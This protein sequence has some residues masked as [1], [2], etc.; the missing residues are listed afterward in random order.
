LINNLTTGDDPDRAADSH[1][2]QVNGLP[3]GVTVAHTQL[4][5][6]GSCGP[7]HYPDKV[8]VG[9]ACAGGD[10][11]QYPDLYDIT[12]I[13]AP[14]IENMGWNDEF[15]G[16]DVS[17]LGFSTLCGEVFQVY[18]NGGLVSCGQIENLT[19]ESFTATGT[20]FSEPGRFELVLVDPS[21]PS[22]PDKHRQGPAYDVG[23]PP[24]KEVSIDR[25]IPASNFIGDLVTVRGDHFIPYPDSI[26]ITFFLDQDRNITKTIHP[27]AVNYDWLPGGWDSLTFKVPEE[28]RRYAGQTIPFEV[29]IETD[30]SSGQTHASSAFTPRQ[31]ESAAWGDQDL[32]SFGESGGYVRSAAVGDIDGDGINDLVV[33]VP[34]ERSGF[35]AVNGAVYI[36]FGPVEGASLPTGQQYIDLAE[37]SIA[38][39]HWDVVIYGDD[40]DCYLD[41]QFCRRIGGALALGDVNGDGVNDILIGTTD[42][43]DAGL[44]DL[45]TEVFQGNKGHLPGKAFVFFGRSRGQWNRWYEIARDEYDVLIHG[46]LQRE[47][48]KQVAIGN[49]NG[50]AYADLIVSAPSQ[51]YNASRPD[52]DWS[53]RVYVIF[54]QETLPREI[55][56]DNDLRAAVAGVI[57][58][59]ESEPQ[60]QT[61]Y[62]GDLLGEGL[63]VGDMDGD[64]RDD[65]A[66]GAPGFFNSAFDVH[67]RK[68]AVF[69]F[70]GAG[71]F[72][73]PG[74]LVASRSADLGDQDLLIAGPTSPQSPHPLHRG[75]EIGRS[76][77][78]GDLDGDGKG[79][80]VLAAP[81]E[82]LDYQAIIGMPS[83]HE[84]H[85]GRI[86]LIEG[87]A[88][89]GSGG[90][91]VVDLARA[92]IHG[93]T[94]ISRLGGAMAVGDVNL[95]GFL[96]LVA[97]AP[98]KQGSE[99]PG[100]VWGFHGSPQLPS[101]EIHLT[102]RSGVPED[103]IIRG[104]QAHPE[105]AG[106]FGSFVTVGDLAPFAGDDVI[107]VDPLA[108]A[109]EPS[110]PAHQTW[111]E[112]AGMLYAF[113]EGAQLFLPR[114]SV[115]PAS[116]DFG[117]ISG[118]FDR[119][120]TIDVV[121]IG[122]GRLFIA[123][124]GTTTFSPWFS[125]TNDCSGRYLLPH[126][127]CAISVSLATRVPGT[128]SGILQI[129]SNDPDQGVID[130]PVQVD[131]LS[132]PDIQVAPRDIE[133]TG[134]PLGTTAS[135]EVTVTNEGNAALR[136]ASFDLSASVHYSFSE[137]CPEVLEPQAS[138][139]VTVTY[140]PGNQ[141]NV[142]HWATLAVLSDDPD[143]PRVEVNLSGHGV[144]PFISV[145]PTIVS[146]GSDL[147]E[148]QITLNNTSDSAALQWNLT[149]DL[150]A[151]LSVSEYGGVL[152]PQ[153]SK[154]LLL[155]VDRS[156]LAA[157]SYAH[158]LTIV[159]NGG[160]QSVSLSMEAPTFLSASPASIEF[161]QARQW[162]VLPIRNTS[163]SDTVLEWQI[164][165]ALPP[166][167]SAS[168][169][170]G[171]VPV[172]STQSVLLSVDR[173]GLAVGEYQH[174]LSLI[175]NGGNQQIGIALTVA[176]PL[177]SFAH[178]FGGEG[179][180]YAAAVRVT[181]DGGFILI[182]LT[183]SF[184]GGN[185]DVWLLKLDGNGH[186]QWEKTIGAINAERGYD[187][188]ETADHGY[189][190][191]AG[192]LD[193][194]GDY[195]L[196]V[197]KLTSQGEIEWQRS[198]GGSPDDNWGAWGINF[199]IRQTGEGGY[200]VA[201][202]TQGFGA[203]RD[204]V[205]ILKL[206]ARGE[207]EWQKRYGGSGDDY[208][209]WIEQT[210]D[211]G[212]IVAGVTESFGAGGPDIWVLKLDASGEVEWQKTYGGS[213]WD[214]GYTIRPTT[215][216]G[217][218]LL[219]TT[220][221]FGG[222]WVLK[223]DAS[224]DVT[225]QKAY[226]G[227]DGRGTDI[228]QTQEGGYILSGSLYTPG[229]GTDAWL[230]KL[231]AAGEIEWQ[232]TYG[233]DRV[234]EFLTVEQTP[235]GGFVAGG[236]SWSFRSD[237]YGADVELWVVRTDRWGSLGN[238][239]NN[240]KVP[241]VSAVATDVIP[242]QSSVDPIETTAEPVELGFASMDSASDVQA[243]CLLT[244]SEWQ[245]MEDLDINDIPANLDFSAVPVEP[246]VRVSQ[247]IVVQNLGRAERLTLD[248]SLL[249]DP[250]FTLFSSCPDQLLPAQSCNVDVSFSPQ[251]E[252]ERSARLIVQSN[253]P[254][255][256]TFQV[257]ITGTGQECIKCEGGSI[258]PVP[259][260]G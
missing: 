167:L 149:E 112:K 14:I 129:I 221:T 121:N 181:S 4:D 55:Q 158:T 233:G 139:K 172:G 53:G 45:N 234:D 250:D 79:E 66:V 34:E 50:D 184:G 48:G 128:Y 60:G 88:L 189:V 198:Y 150:P 223:L 214:L 258:I 33:G 43:N 7:Y 131:I 61:V 156:G 177:V 243:V 10:V 69:L 97:G 100:S 242:Q 105:S 18:W 249:G 47:L 104:D 35:G 17:G 122:S 144:P 201:G 252:G 154:T 205:W 175:S 3:S 232:R 110:D 229:G 174:T 247:S 196:L 244:E 171:Q 124:V 25:V 31:T 193:D 141:V 54:G 182:G 224:G 195:N 23:L 56:V 239:C 32:V 75:W 185:E 125:Q 183:N 127:R 245:Q 168:P 40:T 107:V 29:R 199:S 237:Q 120:E 241:Q 5:V 191:V 238:V 83:I 8:C 36:A 46:D 231:D 140:D 170:S 73:R 192:G 101:G 160:S 108:R 256:S 94:T 20:L 91:S 117:Q 145:I 99:E 208:A 240:V 2:L 148:V 78:I 126:D 130:I 213:D 71:S 133:F 222:A 58:S 37:G 95:D 152:P 219:G 87:S 114:I 68:G 93:T 28:L 19:W 30:T 228:R 57:I 235:E 90:Q 134:V 203:A 218:V 137:A 220:F 206:D 204:D 65:L 178:A 176:E 253:D 44:H 77:V 82:Y 173:S 159:S 42:Q 236:D 24:Y 162:A 70:R 163:N 142:T 111:R 230:L 76:L 62:K 1:T 64:G 119:S 197:F 81:D 86:Y 27:Q 169:S 41:G 259:G 26:F 251:Q 187:I 136:L 92:I 254:D 135:R 52:D 216:G 225:W 157:G 165:D 109:P 16:W 143:E 98:G 63:A 188:Q 217:Y 118:G 21:D 102:D 147:S 38:S 207:V 190:L 146:F 72:D 80:L 113:Y 15:G 85:I 74:H 248:L 186:L 138:C 96:D 180:E 202:N 200:V 166:W 155:N 106:G 246:G 103:F 13:E 257:D 6:E 153:G 115:S 116:V 212:Y 9:A 215:D 12:V 227:F 67:Y 84:D 161:G 59:G 210:E 39:S 49:L 51:P 11:P 164:E 209:N 255:E 123:S 22:N 132:S 226:G 179:G 89:S 260:G 151:W 194:D 211:A